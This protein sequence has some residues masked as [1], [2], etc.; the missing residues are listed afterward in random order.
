[1]VGVQA[2]EK[3]FNDFIAGDVTCV[4]P[5]YQRN[6]N[7]KVENCRRLFDDI[8]S[9]IEDDKRDAQHFIGTFV[10]RKEQDI[11]IFNKYIIIDGQQ[12]IV[13]IILFVR[14]L[15]NFA[16]EDLKTDINARFLRHT[17]GQMKNSCRLRPTEFDA[18]VFAKIMDGAEGFTND[19]KNSSMYRAYDFF[20]N[21]IAAEHIAPQKLFNAIPRLKVVGIRLDNEKPQEIFESLNST[22]LDL[23][24]ADLIRNFLLMNADYAEQ[25]RLYKNYWWTMENLLGDKVQTFVMQYLV[26]KLESVDVYSTK[27]S[28]KN[29]YAVFKR[30]FAEKFFNTEDCLRDMLRYAE[31]FRRCIFNDE[32]DF[33]KLSALDKKFFEL[34]FLLKANNAPIVLMY[35]LDRHERNHFNSAT[36]IKFL[37]ALISF[38]FRAKVCKGTGITAQFAG[39]MLARLSRE[40]TLD[41]KTFWREITFGKGRST[42]PNN[43]DFQAALTDGNLK[44]AIKDNELFKYFLYALEKYSS[45][46]LPAYASV[47]IEHV[48]PQRLNDWWRNHLTHDDEDVAAFWTNS[49]GNMALVVDK[50]TESFESK[51]IRYGLSPFS[52]TRSLASYSAWT[53]KQ[54]QAR[55]KKLATAAVNV[56]TLPEEFNTTIKS[57]A[58]VFYLDANFKLFRGEHPATISIFGNTISTFDK[59]PLV[60]WNHMV[61]EVVRQLYALDADK[62]RRAAQMENVR[63]N[64]FTTESTDF[65]IDESFY[66]R[67]GFDT[68]TCLKIVKVLTENFDGLAG[69]NFRDDIWFTLKSR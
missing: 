40:E 3:S 65:K 57:T 49:L 31:F 34:T 27:I 64:L 46:N 35:L 9:I 11:S 47:T 68:E 2:E 45:Q 66:M 54:I 21:A 5:V 17:S 18:A 63:H 43:A 55:A 23:S 8:I 13:S 52:S 1:M 12:R 48:L 62:F 20:R 14:A 24:E 51:K 67:T 37:D 28:D 16:D 32:T 42:F 53:S 60:H 4:I 22:G 41:A 25:E 58:D 6:Y 44:D 26:A 50:G 30:F 38:V 19:E 39:N 7:W 33:D 15:C 29:L 10:Y 69:T 56:W 59:K 61:R 36:F